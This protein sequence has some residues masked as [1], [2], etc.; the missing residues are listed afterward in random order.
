MMVIKLFS[1][2]T[3]DLISQ[4]PMI[5]PSNFNDE[6]N[7]DLKSLYLKALFSIMM[8]LSKDDKNLKILQEDAKFMDALSGLKDRVYS[9]YEL[10]TR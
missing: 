6:D 7:L 4:R 5:Q 1:N 2:Y 3:R 9:K 10:L 8:K